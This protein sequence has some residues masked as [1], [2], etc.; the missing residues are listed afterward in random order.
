MRFDS[1]TSMIGRNMSGFIWDPFAI[2]F[3]MDHDDLIGR[4]MGG[5]IHFF[6]VMMRT[7]A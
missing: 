6:F 3:G 7:V 2:E 1:L 4:N 5:F